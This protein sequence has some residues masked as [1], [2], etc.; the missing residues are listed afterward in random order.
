MNPFSLGEV[1]REKS[2]I[3]RREYFALLGQCELYYL[4]FD[5]REP[6]VIT[7][8]Y[9]QGDQSTL[10]SL[11]AEPGH[12][13]V[14]FFVSFNDARNFKIRGWS[15]APASIFSLESID[16]GRLEIGIQGNGADV[17]FACSGVLVS[18]VKTYLA[19]VLFKTPC[20]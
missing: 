16:S 5:E 6:S 15:H 18:H 3:S 17:S 14:S 7:A 13:T 12:N 1:L 11:G 20:D 19:G 9:L 8:F 10:D 2:A 4:H